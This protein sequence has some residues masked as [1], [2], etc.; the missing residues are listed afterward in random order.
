MPSLCIPY[1]FMT[2]AHW[3]INVFHYSEGPSQEMWVWKE[4]KGK[5]PGRGYK[6][7][8]IGHLENFRTRGVNGSECQ[9][10][11][12]MTLWVCW[13]VRNPSREM[14]L[15]LCR[16]DWVSRKHLCPYTLEHPPRP[17]LKE[18][19]HKLT[20]VSWNFPDRIQTNESSH[21]QKTLWSSAHCLFI[22]LLQSPLFGGTWINSISFQQ[23]HAQLLNI[24]TTFCILLWFDSSTIPLPM[25][26]SLDGKI[27]LW[28]MLSLESNEIAC[29]VT[30]TVSLT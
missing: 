2:F 20:L 26:Q 1:E 19:K 15:E 6:L 14:E 18:W 21:I 25:A 22:H 4:G 10:I 3:G 7:A 28:T 11:Q 17:I 13:K 29:P 23:W 5:Q 9:E 8:I 27:L 30:H 16:V 12:N 24:K